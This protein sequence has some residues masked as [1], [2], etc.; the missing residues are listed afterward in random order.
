MLMQSGDVEETSVDK[1]QHAGL[2][3]GILAFACCVQEN[4]G[5]AGWMELHFSLLG[6][7][8]TLQEGAT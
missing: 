8:Q 4:E 2:R 7:F 1:Y 5:A 3:S 6:Q